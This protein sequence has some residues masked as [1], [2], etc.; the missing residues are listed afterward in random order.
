MMCSSRTWS[1][2]DRQS[3]I[4][5]G[6]APCKT[7]GP[8]TVSLMLTTGESGRAPG[9]DVVRRG[10]TRAVLG[11]MR[12]QLTPPSYPSADLGE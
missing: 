11:Y 8:S 1:R 7:V 2:L 12:S 6:C 5:V 3:L 9:P 4:N 10:Q